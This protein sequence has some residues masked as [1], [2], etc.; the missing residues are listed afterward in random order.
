MKSRLWGDNARVMYLIIAAIVLLL[1]G[2]GAR[3]IWT[4]E[5]RWADTVRIMFMHHDFLHPYLGTQD[6]YDKPLLSYW[7]IAGL[8]T[9]AGKLSTTILRLPCALSGLLAIYSIYVIGCQLKDRKL[10]L[11]AGWMLLTTFYFVFWARTSSADMLNLAGTLFAVAWYF[12]SKTTPSFL[13]YV[14]FFIILAVT[15]LC[16]GLVGPVVAVLAILTDVALHHDWRRHLRLNVLLAAIPAIVIYLLPFWASSH[17]GDAQYRENG[18]MLVWRENVLRYFQ[19][20]DHKGPL[21]TYFL[22]LPIYLLPWTLFFIPAL[23]SAI[24]N[25]QALPVS[26]KWATLTTLILFIFFTASGSRRNYYILPVVPFAL[27]M[28][29]HWILQG[30]N[31]ARTK[32]AAQLAIVTLV[33]FIANFVILQPLYYARGGAADFAA[34][35]QAHVAPIKPWAQ[36]HIVLL[37]PESKLRFYLDLSPDIAMHNLT[38]TTRSTQTQQSLLKAW[39]FLADADKQT[40]TIYITRQRYAGMLQ[41]ILPHYHQVTAHKGLLGHS[42]QSDQPV[43]FVPMS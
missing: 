32:R 5:H 15:A 23:V 28:T 24:R 1:F 40:D 34:T 41:G 25:W 19:P 31:L 11:L 18:L 13:R 35:L 10:G 33:V 43:A 2:L 4:Q 29:A 27:L 38:G 26:A 20:F 16:K 42:K 9:L 37:D 22:Y 8:A 12:Q 30:E 17:F 36:W 14:I 21:Y 7:L 39:P 6:Y 3:E